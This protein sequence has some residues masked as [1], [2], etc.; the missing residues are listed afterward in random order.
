MVRCKDCKHWGEPFDIYC[1][2]SCAHCDLFDNSHSFNEKYYC[3]RG[4]KKKF[5]DKTG[6][7]IPL[8]HIMGFMN[9]PCSEYFKCSLCEYEHYTLFDLPP[10]ECPNCGA[11]MV[12]EQE[13]DN[14]VD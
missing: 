7:W 2:S 9:H 10:D 12:L 13:G 6:K 8:G 1:E 5:S 4:E 3:A 14:E 11:K